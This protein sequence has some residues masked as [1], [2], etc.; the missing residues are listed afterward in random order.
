LKISIGTNIQEG[1][2]GGGNLFAINF[3]EFL[4]SNGH[5]VVFNLDDEDIDI[6][7]LTEPRRT[8]P[9]SAFTNYNVQDYILYRNPD[10]LAVHRINE[11]DE[12][13]DTNFINKYI[14]FA[15]RCADATVFVS[16]WI[17]DIYVNYEHIENKPYEVILAGANKNIFNANNLVKWNKKNKFKLVTHHWSNNWNKG[18]DVYKKIDELLNEKE[19]KDLVEFNFIGRL[20]DNLHLKNTNVMPPKHGNDLA[21]ELKNNNFYITGTINEPSG[22]HHIEAAQ[23]GLPIM[24]INSG[25]VKEYCDGFGVEFNINNLKEKIYEAIENYEDHYNKIKT[26]NK[27]SDIMCTDFLNFFEELMKKKSF[28]QESRSLPRK[29]LFKLIYSKLS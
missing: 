18:F 16:S 27:N 1:P 8:S 24:Y 2:W 13:K 4:E 17:K 12:H 15:N 23:C 10:A 9:S 26:Y 28:L 11:C 21:N 20:P 5:K 6:I 29:S 3:K 25:G 19:F 22:N 14:A 7:L